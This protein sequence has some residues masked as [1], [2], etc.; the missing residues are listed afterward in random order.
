MEV[1]FVQGHA[2]SFDSY[3]IIDKLDFDNLQNI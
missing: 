3:V 2:F 1:N